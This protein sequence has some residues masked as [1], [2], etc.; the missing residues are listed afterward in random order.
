[1]PM[2]CWLARCRCLL[3]RGLRHLR[4]GGWLYLQGLR[5]HPDGSPRGHTRCGATLLAPT[6]ALSLPRCDQACRRQAQCCGAM[7]PMC[8]TR[9][10]GTAPL[11]V[12]AWST[13][14]PPPAEPPNNTRTHTSAGLIKYTAGLVYGWESGGLNEAVSDIFGVLVQFWA[15]QTMDPVSVAVVG[16]CASVVRWEQLAGVFQPPPRIAATRTLLHLGLGCSACLGGARRCY[17]RCTTAAQPPHPGRRL[18]LPATRAAPLQGNYTI[19]G[20]NHYDPAEYTRSMTLPSR[21]GKSLDYLPPDGLPRDPLDPE[22][23]VS[24]QH[25]VGSDCTGRLRRRMVWGCGDAG[26]QLPRVQGAVL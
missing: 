11:L 8:A 3:C 12:Q 1:M 13:A 16:V 9:P 4:P 23:W 25:A 18:S 26:S 5:R 20:L 15:N 19:G 24:H 7:N 10:V 17:V 14:P 22:D 21:D 2:L 6:L